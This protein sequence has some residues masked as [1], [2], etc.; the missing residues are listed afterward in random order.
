M[1]NGLEDLSRH[2]PRRWRLAFKTNKIERACGLDDA[3]VPKRTKDEKG[4]KRRG[5]RWKKPSVQCIKAVEI[6]RKW[7]GADEEKEIGPKEDRWRITGKQRNSR[8][9]FEGWLQ[10]QPET[11]RSS[12]N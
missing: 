9:E 6:G 2:H 1:R 11:G 3:I 5:R 10:Q 4:G 12:S 7:P 8:I